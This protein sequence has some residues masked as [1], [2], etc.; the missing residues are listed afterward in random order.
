M[1]LQEK[2]GDG[3]HGGAAALA[4]VLESCSAWHVGEER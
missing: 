4:Q 3:G 1:S 2:C